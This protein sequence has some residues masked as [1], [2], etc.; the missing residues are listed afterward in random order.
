MDK[1]L[2]RLREEHAGVSIEGLFL[3]GAAHADVV[4]CQSVYTAKK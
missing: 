2:H 3:G 1:L 4:R